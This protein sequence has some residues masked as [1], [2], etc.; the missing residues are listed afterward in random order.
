MR[1]VSSPIDMM[2]QPLREA[3]VKAAAFSLGIALAAM[4]VEGIDGLC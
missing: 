2:A 1:P 3:A 4:V